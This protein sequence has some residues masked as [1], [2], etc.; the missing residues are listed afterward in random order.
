MKWIV[1]LILSLFCADTLS[2]E[3]VQIVDEKGKTVEIKSKSIS[4]PWDKVDFSYRPPKFI[5]RFTKENFS[6]KDAAL[7]I[8]GAP[9]ALLKLVAGKQEQAASGQY[10]STSWFALDGQDVSRIRDAKSVEIRVYFLDQ[11][12]ATWQVPVE[13]L[14]EWKL[15][16]D[17]A[18]A[19]PQQ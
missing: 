13:I 10:E 5:L 14:Q 6:G 2:A 18:R 7:V 11:P 12:S 4:E 9:P 3:V 17:T 8:D 19:L 16:I 15:V 1:T